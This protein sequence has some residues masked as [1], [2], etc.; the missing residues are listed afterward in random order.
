MANITFFVITTQK[1]GERRRCIVETWGRRVENLNFYS[2]HHS[3]VDRCIKVSE[4]TTYKSGMEKQ[5]A[6]L[7]LL[8]RIGID[9]DR[10]YFFCDDD[11]YVNTDGINNYVG[12]ADKSFVHCNR[13]ILGECIA[14]LEKFVGSLEYPSGGAGFLVHGS[15]LSLLIPF[16]YKPTVYGDVAFGLNLL[17]KNSSRQWYKDPGRFFSQSPETC[18]HDVPLKGALSYHYIKI[19]SQFQRL[20]RHYG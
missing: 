14:G 3:N 10:W 7:N 2:D 5:I 15:L 20:Y 9:A 1:N 16:A 17:S 13:L 18:G 4:D 8:G 6:V 11:T 19:E 12:T